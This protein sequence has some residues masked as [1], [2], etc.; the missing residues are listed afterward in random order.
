MRTRWHPWV[1][2]VLLPACAA[3]PTPSAS[4]VPLGS[5]A[6]H[7]PAAFVADGAAEFIFPADAPRR[8]LPT[9]EDSTAGYPGQGFIW[10]VEWDRSVGPKDASRGVEVRG[11][12]PR[13]VPP[14]EDSLAAALAQAQRSHS[15]ACTAGDLSVYCLNPEPALRAELRAGRVV[16]TVRGRPVLRRLWPGGAPDSV[17]L[18]WRGP[19]LQLEARQVALVRVR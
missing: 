6:V 12:V 8:L 19:G 4:A 7:G 9:R 1:A 15:V 14:G 17:R 13:V 16:L 18:F 2:A 10:S 5:D 11:G 3:R